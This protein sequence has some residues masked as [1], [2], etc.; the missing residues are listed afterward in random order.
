MRIAILT[1]VYPSLEKPDQRAFIHARAQLY[2][3]AGHTVRVFAEGGGPRQHAEQFED[4]EILRTHPVHLQNEI[5]SFAPN[6]IAFHT[7]YAGT[8]VY[9][10]AVQLVDHFPMVTWVHGY[11]AMYTAFHG[12]HHGWRRLTSIPWDARKLW[13]L[14]GFL[15]QCAGVVYVSHWLQSMAERS[16]YYHHP[17]SEVIHNPVDLQKFALSDLRERAK[18]V[19]GLRGIALRSL[20]PKYGLDLAIQAYA[21]LEETGLTI[22]GTGP[23]ERELRALIDRTHS[24]TTLLAQ[25]FPHAQVPQLLQQ[26]DYFVAPSRNETQGLAMCEAMAC[27][28][29]VIATQVGGIPEFVRDGVDGYLVS[30]E[31]PTALRAAIEKMVLNPVQFCQMGKNARQ[32]MLEICDGSRI[33]EKELHVLKKA[34]QCHAA[35]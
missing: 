11:E 31:N 4:I 30:P 33:A 14:R 23:L 34:T 17:Y 27:G 2:Q 29:P 8:Q 25:G 13:H 18:T 6:V 24:H 28:L 35:S 22:I 19:T 10:V 12:Y 9:Q 3:Q 16:M 15:R 1:E 32:H 5:K 26:Y 7:P 20:G 21:G